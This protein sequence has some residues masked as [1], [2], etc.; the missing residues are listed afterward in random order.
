M[1]SRS[2]LADLVAAYPRDRIGKETATLYLA[3]L[4]DVPIDVLA[5][6]VH[7]LICTSERFP[8]V[9]AIREAV[10]ERLARLPSEDEALAQVEAYVALRRRAFG[11]TGS[12]SRSPALLPRDPTPQAL[13]PVVRAALELVGGSYA[14]RRAEKPEVVRGQFLRVYREQR[15]RAV[16]DLQVHTRAL[17]PGEPPPLAAVS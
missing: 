7:D 16:R 15:A 8:T 6:V 10:A 5:A 13:H 4:A 12:T 14:Y 1:D 17:G 9:R 2:C 11:P 3:K